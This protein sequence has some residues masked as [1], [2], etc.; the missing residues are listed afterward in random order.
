MYKATG[1][2]RALLSEIVSMGQKWDKMLA[3]LR[4]LGTNTRFRSMTLAQCVT[5]HSLARPGG[6]CRLGCSTRRR[7]GLKR[8]PAFPSSPAPCCARYDTVIR[9]SR[10]EPERLCTDAGSAG[11][12]TTLYKRVGRSIP[13]T[14]RGFR[15]VRP[16]TVFSSSISKQYWSTQR[17]YFA[18]HFRRSWFDRSFPFLTKRGRPQAR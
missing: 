17:M 11:L 6:R 2:I 18:V 5:T 10:K 15:T 16:P 14:S 13:H 4:Q 1:K 3:H 7:H 9:A 12:R 8:A